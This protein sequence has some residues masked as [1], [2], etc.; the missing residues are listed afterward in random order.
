MDLGLTGKKAV[1]TGSTAGIGFAT[2]HALAREGAAVTIT[3][4]TDERVREAIARL[5]REVPG[6]TLDGVACDLG[7]AASCRALIAHHPEVDELVNNV[8]IIE[9]KPFEQL[10]DED[11]LRFFETNVLSG[12]GQGRHKQARQGRRGGG[13]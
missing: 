6:A 4:R 9:P 8:G 5:K 10:P 11:W 1:G 3:G 12:V 2:A 7:G 13:P